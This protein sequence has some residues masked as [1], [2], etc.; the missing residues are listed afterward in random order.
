LGSDPQVTSSVIGM[1]LFNQLADHCE[2]IKLISYAKQQLIGCLRAPN[3]I[4][5]LR[6]LNFGKLES[7]RDTKC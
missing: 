4:K 5:T 2:I 3:I 7:Q 1:A 6:N